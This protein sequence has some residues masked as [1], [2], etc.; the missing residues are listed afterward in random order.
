M[1]LRRSWNLFGASV[2]LA[3]VLGLVGSAGCR[4]DGRATGATSGGS[5]GGDDGSGGSDSSSGSGSSG[6]NTGSGGG[7]S[8]TSGAGS[9]SGGSTTSGGGCTGQAATIEDVTQEKI[10]VGVDVRLDGVVAMSQKFL[11]SKG[12][13]TGSCLWGVFVS[14][15]GLSVTKE[16]SGILVLSYGKKAEIP[17]GGTEAFCPRLG[18]D[19]VGDAIPDDV[20]PGDV[21]NVIG[22]TGYFLLDDCGE[23]P[24]GSKVAQRQIAKSCLVE[25]T[26]K[27]VTPPK[28]AVISAENLTKL[29]SPSDKKYHDAWGGVKV[30][31]EN[32]SAELQDGAV[33]GDFGFIH[34]KEGGL[35]VGDKLYYRGY[36][37]KN[38]CHAAPVF[39]E[40]T[41]WDAIEGISYLNFCTWTLEPNDKCNDFAPPSEDC[42]DGMSCAH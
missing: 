32:V 21:L 23:E 29:A 3:G 7:S 19:E 15:P 6:G 33:V 37:K 16:Y 20:K 38:P 11:V 41:S 18:Q 12:S 8:S 1:V 14:S 31:V 4:G 36:D 24:G 9:G 42:A 34:L 10:G 13:S 28:A 26:G 25:K 35:R 5:G 40:T 2:L 39:E 27:T 30:R 22:E 17:E